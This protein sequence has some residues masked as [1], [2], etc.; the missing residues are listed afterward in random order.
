VSHRNNRGFT[1]IEM[2]VVLAIIGTL[3]MIVAPSVLRNVSD[4]NV[5]AAKTQIEAFAVA[6]DGYRLDTGTYPNTEQGLSA[7]RVQ[8]IGEGAQPGWRG[9]YLRKNV[10]LDP[11]G[12]PYLFA[13][14]GVNNPDS[15]DLY[16]LGRDGLPGGDGEDADITSWG[17]KPKS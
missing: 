14:P 4:A 11:W 15:Y 9:P 6:L 1:L 16:T 3:A 7:L 8:P 12:H 5:N 17:G 10:P 13:S 2:M